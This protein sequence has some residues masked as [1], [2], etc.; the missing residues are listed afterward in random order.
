MADL[1]DFDPDRADWR[2]LNTIFGL[3]RDKTSKYG[4]EGMPYTKDSERGKRY[5]KTKEVFRWILDQ[6]M[7]E[8][9]KDLDEF[10][11][12]VLEHGAKVAG[13]LY[14]AKLTKIQVDKEESRVIDIDDH[15]E[16]LRSIAIE[17][18][19]SMQAVGGNVSIQCSKT[20]SAEEIVNIINEQVEDILQSLHNKYCSDGED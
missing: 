9:T 3:S 13:E 15:K 11:A 20:Q 10:D 4:D 5:H 19:K 14:R 12:L 18:R 16:R 1:I 2:D 17:F 7:G 6:Q 8:K